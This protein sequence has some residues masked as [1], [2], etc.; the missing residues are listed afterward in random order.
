MSQNS[1]SSAVVMGALRIKLHSLLVNSRD[2]NLDAYLGDYPIL[3]YARAK[4]DPECDLR[5]LTTTFGEDG[6]G[7]GLPKGSPLKVAILLDIYFKEKERKN[8]IVVLAQGFRFSISYARCE[9]VG[10]PA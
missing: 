6:Y 8:I 3:D 7:I 5:L 9:C 4:L 1:S 10:Q 2:G